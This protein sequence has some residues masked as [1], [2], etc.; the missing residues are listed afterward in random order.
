MSSANL[1]IP[2]SFQRWQW[3]FHLQTL[4]VNLIIRSQLH[5]DH[6][7]SRFID[8]LPHQRYCFLIFPW[9]SWVCWSL[10][11]VF[12]FQQHEQ[13]WF[14][15]HTCEWV[16]LINKEILWEFHLFRRGNGKCVFPG[17]GEWLVRRF[18]WNW[19]T[20]K[21]KWPVQLRNCSFKSVCSICI[22]GR[23]F[24]GRMGDRASSITDSLIG[25]LG[26]TTKLSFGLSGIK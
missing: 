9:N 19:V 7:R 3:T 13:M 14:S 4:R 5:I 22:F 24:T 18:L 17:L 21:C 12:V 16:S 6:F 20:G 11:L 26:C 10:F 23:S 8:H 25:L 1:Q 2:Q 15:C